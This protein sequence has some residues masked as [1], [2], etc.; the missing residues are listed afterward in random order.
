MLVVLRHELDKRVKIFVCEV[1]SSRAVPLLDHLGKAAIEDIGDPN[2]FVLALKLHL[3]EIEGL[4]SHDQLS[5]A[6]C[7]LEGFECSVAAVRVF[8]ES[9]EAMNYGAALDPFLIVLLVFL[10]LLAIVRV[11]R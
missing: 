3:H 2:A 7:L 4:M 1:D 10:V 5:Q 11:T 9:H 8:E 6:V